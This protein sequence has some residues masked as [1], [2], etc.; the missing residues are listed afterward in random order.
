MCFLEEAQPSARRPQIQFME[1]QARQRNIIFFGIEESETSYH[2]LEN[3]MLQFLCEHF[4]LKLDYREIQEIKR[5][6]KKGN[7]PRP[8]IVTFSTLGTKINILKKIRLLKDTQYHLNEDYPKV[9]IRKKKRTT[10]R[11]K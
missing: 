7:K 5:V 2:N 6:G 11:I 10:G 4:S 9:H 8:I 3:N 1:K